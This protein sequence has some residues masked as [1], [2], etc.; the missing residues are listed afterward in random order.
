M[1]QLKFRG[2]EGKE[3]CSVSKE[4]IDELQELLQCPRDYFVLECS[5][6]TFISEGNFINIYPII[7]VAWFDRGQ[8]LQDKVA[9][10]ITKHVESLGYKDIDVVFSILDEKKYYENGKHF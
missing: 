6:S 2:V 5:N 8:E 7:D 4:L 9:E 1:P 3:I 10:I